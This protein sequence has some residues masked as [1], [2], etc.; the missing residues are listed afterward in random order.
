MQAFLLFSFFAVALHLILCSMC[1]SDLAGFNKF[2]VTPKTMSSMYVSRWS[3]QT[4]WSSWLVAVIIPTCCS[5]WWPWYLTFSWVQTWAYLHAPKIPVA[6]VHTEPSHVMH[7]A[8]WH[9]HVQVMSNKCSPLS[10]QWLS[11]AFTAYIGGTRAC[12]AHLHTCPCMSC[13]VYVHMRTL[14]RLAVLSTFV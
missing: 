12:S 5:C 10:L 4:S 11:L 9:D 2:Y 14:L 7:F 8:L 3:E 13:K 6:S 1:C